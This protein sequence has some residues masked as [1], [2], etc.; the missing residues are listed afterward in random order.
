MEGK[1]H[2]TEIETIHSTSNSEDDSCEEL[3]SETLTRVQGIL[4]EKSES[5]VLEDAVEEWEYLKSIKSE[6]RSE[7][8]ICGKPLQYAYYLKN[9]ENNNTLCIG[10]DCLN[11][12]D[13]ALLSDTITIVR[14]ELDNKK[15]RVCACCL[16]LRINR[17]NPPNKL[18][19]NSCY[20]L[21]LEINQAYKNLFFAACSE[22]GDKDIAPG[23]P[24]WKKTCLEC[25]NAK[26]EA[27]RECNQCGEKRIS[28]KESEYTKI[29]FPCKKAGGKKHC[30]S[31]GELNIWV[32][33]K[34]R[35]ICIDCWKKNK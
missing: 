33:E 11:G 16:K 29:C 10:R 5:S 28:P 22:C 26:K 6:T 23:S 13:N 17:I 30:T 9:G 20:T 27:C 24:E 18:K 31:C 15:R 3:D 21:G 35:K 4:L 14:K 1:I 7:F 8:C 19:C 32:A 12:L 34:W 2:D 25:Y